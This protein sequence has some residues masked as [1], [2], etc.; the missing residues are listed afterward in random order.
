[1]G[2][3]NIIKLLHCPLIILSSA[4]PLINLS[5]NG[6]FGNAENQCL[7]IKFVSHLRLVPS[8]GLEE[9]FSLKLL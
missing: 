3:I 5:Y 4:V 8:R 6:I 1:M 7:K 2:S 9:V